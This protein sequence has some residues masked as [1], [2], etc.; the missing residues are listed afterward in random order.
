[1]M[2]DT[3]SSK[4]K[5]TKTDLLQQYTLGQIGES[6]ARKNKNRAYYEEHLKAMELQKQEEADQDKELKKKMLHLANIMQ[7]EDD[8]DDQNFY[9]ANRNRANQRSKAY[10]GDDDSS[11]SDD[12][13]EKN[14]LASQLSS[15]PRVIQKG[16]PSKASAQQEEDDDEDDAD[17]DIE[18]LIEK[19]EAD[20]ARLDYQFQ[21]DE[22][23]IKRIE[24]QNSQMQQQQE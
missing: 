7:Y 4:S 9:A 24:K 1:M 6:R 17:L 11:S 12:S 2:I 21:D 23:R 5:F 19:N 18:Q 14:T 10:D 3:S 20:D 8:F 16:K 15:A 13:A 22:K